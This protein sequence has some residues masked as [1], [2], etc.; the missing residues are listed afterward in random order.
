[1]LN[2]VNI[3]TFIAFLRISTDIGLL[4]IDNGGKIK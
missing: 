2:F 4:L 1:M 3:I